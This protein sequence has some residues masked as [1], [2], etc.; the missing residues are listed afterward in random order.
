MSNWLTQNFVENRDYSI[1]KGDD[2]G[3]ES[4]ILYDLQDT[5]GVRRLLIERR[6]HS[7]Y[8]LGWYTPPSRHSLRGRYSTRSTGLVEVDRKWTGTEYLK[9]DYGMKLTT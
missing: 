3:A 9:R 5:L 4:W 1:T 2:A 7:S 8:K 6:G